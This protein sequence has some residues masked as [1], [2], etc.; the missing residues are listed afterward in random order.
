M[1]FSGKAI[2]S[3]YIY[4]GYI[5]MAKGSNQAFVGK[6]WHHSTGKSENMARAVTRKCQRED[7]LHDW[8]IRS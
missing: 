6:A 5:D 2:W 4:A 8:Q 7:S 1:I 3:S